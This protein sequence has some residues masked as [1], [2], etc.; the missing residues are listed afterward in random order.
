MQDLIKDN[1]SDVEQ[2]STCPCKPQ[3]FGF[4]LLCDSAVVQKVLRE[5]ELHTLESN[6]SEHGR[7]LVKPSPNDMPRQML[8]VV[9]LK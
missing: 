9:T 7:T 8:F 6:L 5:C 2:D 3:C 1:V 4:W